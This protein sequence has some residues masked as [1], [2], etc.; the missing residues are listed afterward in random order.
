MFRLQLGLLGGSPGEV[1]RMPSSRGSSALSIDTCS[2][3]VG[4][5]LPTSVETRDGPK[6]K[7]DVTR[8]RHYFAA[9]RTT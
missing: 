3:A 5:I 4:G 2:G 9:S 1:L 8:S 6:E 7:E